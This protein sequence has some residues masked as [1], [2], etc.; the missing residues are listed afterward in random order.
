[1]AGKTLK[2]MVTNAEGHVS[3]GQKGFFIEHFNIF[4]TMVRIKT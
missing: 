4:L 3:L 2:R 1:M